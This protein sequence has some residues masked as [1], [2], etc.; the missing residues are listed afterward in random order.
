MST[1][2][3]KQHAFLF[4]ALCVCMYTYIYIYYMICIFVF[5]YVYVYIMYV[6]T[7]VRTY[8]RTYIHTYIHT[9]MHTYIHTYIHNMFVSVKMC[10]YIHIY[11]YTHEVYPKIMLLDRDHP[12]PHGLN[13]RFRQA[14]SSRGERGITSMR[15]KK[16][17]WVGAFFQMKSRLIWHVCIYI[18]IYI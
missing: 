18:Y 3:W 5:V 12:G 9:Y 7:Y 1:Y 16:W 11:V 13:R 8:V 10:T 15:R 6:H 4:I 2:V 14:M 17:A